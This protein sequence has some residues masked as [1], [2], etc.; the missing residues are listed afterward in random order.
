MIDATNCFFAANKRILIV[1]L[2]FVVFYCIALFYF[3][4]SLII[5]FSPS[6]KFKAAKF[7]LWV[8]FGVMLWVFFN[9]REQIQFVFSYSA[10]TFYLSSS[11]YN[12]G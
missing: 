4:C 8:T 11:I 2:L 3:N 1:S 6:N 10:S 5:Q 12:K 9:M 7:A